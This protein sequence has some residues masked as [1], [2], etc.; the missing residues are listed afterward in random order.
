MKI[1]KEMLGSYIGAAVGFVAFLVLGAIPGILFGGYAGLAL[2]GVLFG[3]PVESTI[4]A[5]I[6]TFG[7][8]ALGLLASFSLFVVLGA[9]AGTAISIPFLVAH[10]AAVER[11]VPAEVEESAQGK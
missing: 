3:V 7:G 6:I 1:K 9:L 11:Q 4:V 2:S 8:M 5:Q 10:D